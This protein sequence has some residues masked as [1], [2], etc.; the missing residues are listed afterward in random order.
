MKIE[1]LPGCKLDGVQ[2]PQVN[3]ESNPFIRI[4]PQESA[5]E[6]S[7]AIIKAYVCSSV[8]MYHT[9]FVFRLKDHTTT[10]KSTLE[11]IPLG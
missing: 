6:F 2:T 7:V 3:L 1:T 11:R 5:T 10:I 9:I 8:V 4:S